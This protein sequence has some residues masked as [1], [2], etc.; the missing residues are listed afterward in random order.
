[1]RGRCDARRRLGRLPPALRL[2][3][4]GWAAGGVWPSRRA[5]YDGVRV[6]GTVCLRGLARREEGDR[7]DS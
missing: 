1:M 5:G 4:G 7:L 2:P 3:G 6:D